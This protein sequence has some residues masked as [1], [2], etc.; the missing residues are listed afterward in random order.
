[1]NKIC[2]E[3]K[4]GRKEGAACVDYNP[5]TLQFRA[6]EFLAHI[7]EQPE[8]RPQM[9]RSDN[10]VAIENAKAID[11]DYIIH[12]YQIL[13]SGMKSKWKKLNAALK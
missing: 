10:N 12:V 13:Q 4:G 9:F 8:L 11:N 2:C 6:F 5:K 7:S 3:R 1:M